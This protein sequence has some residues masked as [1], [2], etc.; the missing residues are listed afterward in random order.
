MNCPSCGGELSPSDRF[1]RSCGAPV[2]SLSQAPT[3]AA[4]SP[5]AAAVPMPA[6]IGRLISSDSLP[7]GC[8]F[9]V[10]VAL[11]YYIRFP[12]ASLFNA[13]QMMP[14]VGDL[15]PYLFKGG[16]TVLVGILDLMFNSILMSLAAGFIIFL[17][18][19]LVRSTW[20]A[21]AVFVLLY[22][23]TT[24]GDLSLI[25]WIFALASAGIL[26]LVWF[27]FGFLACAASVFFY[28]LLV[29]FP[30]TPRLSAW[31]SWIGLTG[32]AVLLALALYA[33][34]TSLFG[35]ASLED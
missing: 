25:P 30:I 34:H 5:A 26:V 12:L 3:A 22:S 8:G 13:S 17:V 20:A 11:L 32:L 18:R 31:Y 9:G 29:S 27:R 21:A 28:N 14:S 16:R 19:V 23:L 7:V 24:T 33:F 2:S 6:P 1:C 4:E 15:T 10:A 35:R